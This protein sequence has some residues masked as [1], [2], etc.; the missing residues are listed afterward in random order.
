MFQTYG[1]NPTPMALSEVFIALQTGVM[2]GEENPLSQIHSQK[3]QE[4]QTYLSLT[5]HVYSP[6]FLTA[7]TRKWNALPKPVR[8]TLEQ[9]AKETQQFVYETAKRIDEELL[10]DLKKAGMKVNEADREAFRVAS[11]A[12][13]EEFG[14]TVSDGQAMIETAIA[15]ADL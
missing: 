8:S 9:T 13:Y 14:E 1:A 10:V 4:V 3:F 2:D 11:R 15:L 7:S 12:I 6:S 5:S